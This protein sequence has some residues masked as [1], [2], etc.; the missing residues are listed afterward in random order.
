MVC[1]CS[2]FGMRFGILCIGMRGL[3]LA[4]H[5]AFF[6]HEIS[7]VIRSGIIFNGVTRSSRSD[8]GAALISAGI[9]I[10]RR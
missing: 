7:F 4:S 3:F 2:L 10:L 8:I 1:R 5:F 6:T 9:D